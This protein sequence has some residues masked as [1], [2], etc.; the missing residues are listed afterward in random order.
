MDGSTSAS[1]SRPSPNG[2]DDHLAGVEAGGDFDF[3]AQVLADGHVAE[4]DDAI[5]AGNG[6]IQAIVIVE[7]LVIGLASWLLAVILSVP[8]TYLLDY[9]IGV[10]IFQAPL[11]VIFNWTGSFI[12]LG[13]ILVIAALASAVPAWRASQLTIRETLVYE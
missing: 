11:S 9:S 13:G 4:V 6:H 2:H 1:L 7:G 3:G 8:I 5:G 12:W 10:S